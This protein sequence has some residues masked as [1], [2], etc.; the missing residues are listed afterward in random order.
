MQQQQQPF[1]STHSQL[2]AEIVAINSE[3][4]RWERKRIRLQQQLARAQVSA[5]AAAPTTSP[6]S[7]TTTSDSSNTAPSGSSVD[8]TVDVPANK[9]RVV[10]RGGVQEAI[11]KLQTAPS[12][13]EQ[14]AHSTS[15]AASQPS[16]DRVRSRRM[17]AGLLSHL[18]AA[19]TTLT[20]D[21]N[22]LV[23]QQ[24]MQQPLPPPLT[25]H[26]TTQQLV[27]SLGRC[28]QVEAALQRKCVEYRR[29]CMWIVYQQS[30]QWKAEWLWTTEDSD[31]QQ[32]SIAWRVREMTQVWQVVRE[33]EAKQRREK[34]RQARMERGEEDEE[35]V[36]ARRR[37]E[38]WS[39]ADESEL[40]RLILLDRDSRQHTLSTLAADTDRHDSGR[41]TRPQQQSQQASFYKPPARRQQQPSDD[42]QHSD[43]DRRDSGGS[44]RRRDSV[45]DEDGRD[46]RHSRAAHRRPSVDEFGRDV[47]DGWKSAVEAEGKEEEQETAQDRLAREKAE[48][49]KDEETE[50][51]LNGN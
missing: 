12:D 3:R 10:L 14:R 47:D 49:L 27:D 45:S 29:R 25:Q 19:S 44:K 41:E 16:V 13:D 11:T 20:R 23:Q 4:K 22:T 35:L 34:R 2:E 43:I 6:A 1:D 24:R 50:R 17:F 18:S 28:Q 46:G 48:R 42:W 36:E 31:Q 7:A 32:P 15:D 8:A 37:R 51:L 38:G 33:E 30:E 39:A 21:R 9:R 40:Q 5:G 26:N